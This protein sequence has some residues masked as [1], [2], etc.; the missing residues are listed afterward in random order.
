MCPYTS[1]ALDMASRK[2]MLS[3]QKKNEYIFEQ[4]W[5]ILKILYI[6]FKH[7]PCIFKLLL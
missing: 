7:F 6:L 5:Y 3:K 2:L 4:P 1:L